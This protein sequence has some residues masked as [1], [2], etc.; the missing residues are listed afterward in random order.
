MCP[1]HVP[2]TRPPKETGEHTSAI[3]RIIGMNAV[4]AF[5]YP[6]TDNYSDADLITYVVM[7]V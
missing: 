5:N 3:N 4:L 2:D 7:G 6:A 1:N